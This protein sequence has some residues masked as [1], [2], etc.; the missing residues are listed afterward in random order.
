MSS[1]S[2]VFLCADRLVRARVLYEACGVDPQAVYRGEIRCPCVPR[3][4][5]VARVYQW[6]VAD[7]VERVRQEEGEHVISSD[8]HDG[9]VFECRALRGGRG[10]VAEELGT[11]DLS[12]PLSV[13]LT[14]RRTCVSQK[15]VY[16]MSGHGDYR[17]CPGIEPGERGRMRGG[18]PP[19]ASSTVDETEV[20]STARRGARP[21]RLRH[22]PNGNG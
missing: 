14:L 17:S 21:G 5:S 22:A 7:S 13:G 6:L 9:L 4:K 1:G 18:A 3:A 2:R 20:S 12:A 11:A 16:R 8:R 19:R 10:R 15:P